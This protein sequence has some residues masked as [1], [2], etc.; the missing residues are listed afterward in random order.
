MVLKA[1]ARRFPL[2]E[3]TLYRFILP[4]ALAAVLAAWPAMAGPVAPP[5][6]VG[7]WQG[8]RTA[9]I[10]FTFDDNCSNQYAIAVPMFN[11]KGLKIT[12][13]TVTSWV[14]DWSN[15]QDA[16]AA[17]H[18]IASHTVTHANLGGVTAVQLTNEL[19]NSQTTINAQ[20]PGQQCVTVAYPNCVEPSDAVTAT[21]YIGARTC[22]GS[23]I[24][25]SPGNF[26]SLSSYVC[27]SLGSINSL[28]SFI[29]T[30]NSAAN[31]KGWGVFLIHGI[32]NDGGYS[33]LASATLQATVDYF[34]TNQNRYWIQTFGN[35]VRYIRERNA[36]TVTQ[37]ASNDTTLTVQVTNTLNSA[38]Y[39]FPITLRRPVPTNW[40]AAAVSQNG[41]PVGFQNFV[42]NTTN[43]VM[44]DVVPN[45][46]DV[47]ISRSVPPPVLSNP[48]ASGSTGFNLQLNGNDGVTYEISSS[49]DLVSWSPV[50]TN[51]LNGSSTN[52]Q[53]PAPEGQQF[54][55]AQ[56]VP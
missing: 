16:A 54:Y 13:F 37:I 31:T 34:S 24:P 19:L 50:Q 48:A 35:V 42:L 18:E 11:A 25:S 28:A 26:M 36:S 55:R 47:V 53:L 8:F 10:S 29:N 27:G 38:I 20:I 40:L 33:P 1:F 2:Q 3:M 15:V 51:T 22:S 5:Y 21:Y 23:I 6:E 32:D 52:L 43:Y 45:G 49:S 30:G 14:S 44:F 56:W 9:A 7:T 41:Q 12:L 39:S 46:G 17:G 4:V